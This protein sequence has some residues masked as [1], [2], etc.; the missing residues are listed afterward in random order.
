[1][2]SDILITKLD[3]WLKI[4]YK[5]K[6]IGIYFYMYS[7]VRYRSNKMRYHSLSISF[8]SKSYK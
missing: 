1:M 8:S 5:N 6:H 2:K 4:L 3:S 7:K